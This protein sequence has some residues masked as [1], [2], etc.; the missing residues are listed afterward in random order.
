MCGVPI[1]IL[2]FV[3]QELLEKPVAEV[4]AGSE[5]AAGCHGRRPSG[6][7]PGSA[8]FGSCGRLCFPAPAVA[9]GAL[10][11]CPIPSC[12]PLP[13]LGHVPSPGSSPRGRP[14]GHQEP[15]SQS[16]VLQG[17]WQL[18]R[19]LVAVSRDCTVG[20]SFL[21]LGTGSPWGESQP[22]TEGMQ[23]AWCAVGVITKPFWNKGMSRRVVLGT[24]GPTRAEH[25]EPGV[26]S[27]I[28]RERSTVFPL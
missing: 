26:L 21:S 8:A 23:W 18:S 3:G 13:V 24:R 17:V 16:R 25:R 20:G 2:G 4:A 12:C 15:D 28:R 7:P 11:D 6:A 19:A 27:Q 9:R 14:G 5:V 1:L 22:S 10:C